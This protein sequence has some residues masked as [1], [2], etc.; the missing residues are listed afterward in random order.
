MF[1]PGHS[2][3]SAWMLMEVARQRSD[4]SLLNT[5][6]DIVLAALEHGWDERYGGLRYLTNIDRTPT[7]ELEADMKLWWPHSET[8]YALL[9]GWALTAREDLHRW[10][11]DVH[12]YAFS[13]FPDPLHGEWFGYLN[14]D[15]SPA[16]TAKGNG[17]KGFFHLPRAM[18]RCYQLLLE[19]EKH[20]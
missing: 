17:W 9:L 1:H 19:T 7:H 5:A 16:F 11:E 20:R 13:A 4:E 8:L 15:G 10:Y 2:I 12:E 3:E 6:V 14:R 18:F